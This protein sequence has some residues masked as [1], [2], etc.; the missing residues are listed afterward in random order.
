MSATLCTEC[1]IRLDEDGL[2]QCPEVLLKSIAEL[3]ARIRELTEWCSEAVGA[4]RIIREADMLRPHAFD[5]GDDNMST[6]EM[7]VQLLS[8]LPLPEVKL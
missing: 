7:I 5:R 1:G 4:M 3:E 6:H 2:C 8:S